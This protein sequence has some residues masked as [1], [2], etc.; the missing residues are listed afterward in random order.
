MADLAYHRVPSGYVSSVRR[1]RSIILILLT[2]LIVSAFTFTISSA[3]PRATFSVNTT[4]D[5]IDA[6]GFDNVCADSNGQCSLRAAIM[7]ANDTFGTDTIILPAGTYT[8][9]RLGTEDAGLN[10]DLTS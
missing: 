7:T 5:T 10:G 9:T 4:N 8:I 2:L 6:V 1:S 3:Q